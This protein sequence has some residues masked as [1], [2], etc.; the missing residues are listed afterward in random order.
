MSAGGLALKILSTL[1]S[2]T[3]ESSASAAA[4]C[5][6]TNGLTPAAM[7]SSTASLAYSC[8]KGREQ[9][10]TCLAVWMIPTRLLVSHYRS[11]L[12]EGHKANGSETSI[13]R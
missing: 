10:T 6:H 11:E 13:G 5:E 9:A 4:L 8:D 1:N 12:S 7:R 3:T 2:I